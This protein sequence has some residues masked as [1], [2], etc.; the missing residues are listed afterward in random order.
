MC[1]CINEKCN[2]NTDISINS[3]LATCDGDFA[4]SPKCLIE[5]KKQRDNFFDNISNDNFYKKWLYG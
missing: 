1:K 5:F 3:V 4:C 2:N